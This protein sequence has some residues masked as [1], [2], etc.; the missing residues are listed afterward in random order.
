M[1]KISRLPSLTRGCNSVLPGGLVFT[2][3]EQHCL[4]GAN[5]DPSQAAVEYN[6]EQRNFDCGG[7]RKE[8][9]STEKVK[10]A[11][12]MEEM[13]LVTAD[14]NQYFRGG[15]DDM[16]HDLQTNHMDRT[17]VTQNE[18]TALMRKQ[19][20]GR[21]KGKGQKL[22]QHRR[23]V[24]T[25]GRTNET[26]HIMNKQHNKN[27]LKPAGQTSAVRKVTVRQHANASLSRGNSRATALDTLSPSPKETFTR[28]HEN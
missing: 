3:S 10:T 28:L 19:K 14:W 20:Q 2:Q 17:A 23:L 4:D 15:A 1:K 24:S 21:Q 25:V 27:S 26:L 5:E 18:T 9:V 8:C 13:V 22:S 11:E 6:I 12:N 7:K 16:L